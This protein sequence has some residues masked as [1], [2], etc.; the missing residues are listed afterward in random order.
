MGQP[1]PA[2]VDLSRC[3]VTTRASNICL[4]SNSYL[5]STTIVVYIGFKPGWNKFAEIQLTASKLMNRTLCTLYIVHVYYNCTC[6]FL[7]T[8]ADFKCLILYWCELFIKIWW[9]PI[10]RQMR[11]TKAS[12]LLLFWRLKVRCCRWGENAFWPFFC[13]KR[14]ITVLWWLQYVYSNSAG[15]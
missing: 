1:V 4:N 12:D 13:L 7:H 10:C 3:G 5:V 11:K 15:I 6:T 14:T 8:G 9:V 2:V